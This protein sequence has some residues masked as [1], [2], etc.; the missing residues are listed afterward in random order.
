MLAK[1]QND[2][3]EKNKKSEQE[4][5]KTASYNKHKGRKLKFFSHKPDTSSE[6]SVKH[7]RKQH[8]SS[9]SSDDNK[10]KRKYRPYEEIYGEFK[11]N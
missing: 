2:V 3:K 9:K 7:H 11:K 1:V 8:E 5:P 10:K 4:M 6:E